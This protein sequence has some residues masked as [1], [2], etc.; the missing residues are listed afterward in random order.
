MSFFRKFRKSINNNKPKT[1]SDAIFSLSSAYITLETKLGLKNTARCAVSL[2]SVSGM[3]FSEMKNDIQRFLDASKAEF[4]LSYNIVTDSY[5]Y[6]WVILQ[7]KSME[8]ILAQ[9]IAV[10]DTIQD[11][12]FS[13]HLLAAV[14]EFSDEGKN[15]NNKK[16]RQYLIYN[17]KY[18]KFYPFVPIGQ[19]IRNTEEEMRIMAEIADEISFERDMTLWYPLWDLPL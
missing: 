15:N 11:K 8:D 4:E 3:H 16:H 9:L 7:G 19:E 14:F 2:K 5:G 13:S 10:G 6:L 18:N 12:G 17:Y 1:D